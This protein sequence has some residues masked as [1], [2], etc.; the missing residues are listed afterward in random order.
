LV[1]SGGYGKRDVRRIPVFGEVTVDPDF[2]I[3]RLRG[4]VPFA[5][6]KGE[7]AAAE[8]RC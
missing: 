1:P 2:G 7:A 4:D 5:V 6:E 3:V 8:L